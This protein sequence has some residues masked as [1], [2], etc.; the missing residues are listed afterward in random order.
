MTGV[1]D[2]GLQPERTALAWRR[3][4]L[5]LLVGFLAAGRVLGEL[6]GVWVSVVGVCGAVAAAAMLWR[7]HRRYERHHSQ[8]VGNGERVLVADGGAIVAL[9][10]LTLAAGVTA[11]LVV[12]ALS[13]RGAPALG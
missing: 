9:S 8:L 4:C 10:L 1:F 6:L 3:T 5:A 2:P 12:V 11:V 7:V 13:V